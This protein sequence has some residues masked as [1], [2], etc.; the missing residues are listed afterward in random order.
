MQICIGAHFQDSKYKERLDVPRSPLRREDW[1]NGTPRLTKIR[2]KSAWLVTD[3]IETKWAAA[4]EEQAACPMQGPSQ[5][6]GWG[7]PMGAST[8]SSFP[9]WSPVGW[10]RGLQRAS[11][12]RPAGSPCLCPGNLTIVNSRCKGSSQWLTPSP[13]SNTHWQSWPNPLWFNWFQP[14]SWSLQPG[15]ATARPQLRLP[16]P[17]AES[18]GWALCT[19]QDSSGA[20][21]SKGRLGANLLPAVFNKAPLLRL[22]A[23]L[24][25]DLNQPHIMFSI[26]PTMKWHSLNSWTAQ[27]TSQLLS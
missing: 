2:L 5:Q 16:G 25:K 6:R 27:A 22:L 24:W 8:V 9:R 23:D 13:E 19:E 1:E 10:L 3:W 26:K 7:F 15:R 4:A 21:K 12:T 20:W 11:A 17:L 14:L 18:W